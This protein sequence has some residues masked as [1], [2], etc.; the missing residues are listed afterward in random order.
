VPIRGFLMQAWIADTLHRSTLVCVGG[1]FVGHRVL[2]M[3][4]RGGMMSMDCPPPRFLGVLAGVVDP[5]LV[6]RYVGSQLGTPALKLL[7]SALRRSLT[8]GEVLLVVGNFSH[9]DYDSSPADVPQETILHT[10]SGG[11]P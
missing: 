10:V 3:P 6:R 9:V 4:S 11:S 5:T 8:L 1:M 7:A 2:F